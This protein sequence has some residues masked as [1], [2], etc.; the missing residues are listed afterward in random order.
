MSTRGSRILPIILGILILGIIVYLFIK[1]K[2]K[3]VSCSN[4]MNVTKTIVLPDGMA[5]ESNINLV[6]ST[7]EKG[8]EYLGHDSYTITTGVNKVVVDIDLDDN[9]TI[10]L[11][12]ISFVEGK[13]L[14]MKIN[15]NTKSSEVITLKVGDNYTEGEFMTHLKNNGY[16]CK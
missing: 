16:T 13:D 8:L 14:I 11:N 7:I 5:N 1:K 9:K 3:I 12:N 10:I 2:K 15:P 6:K 4:H